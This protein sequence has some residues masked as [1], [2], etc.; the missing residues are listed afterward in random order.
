VQFGMWAA[1]DD[2][3]HCLSFATWTP[4]LISCCKAHLLQQDV[5]WPWLVRK[6]FICVQ[7]RRGRSNPCC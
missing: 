1:A 7:W 6:Q 2:V 4:R 5:Q 3:N